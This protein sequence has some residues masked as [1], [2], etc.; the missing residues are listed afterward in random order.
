[1]TRTLLLFLLVIL[2]VSYA[3][4][5]PMARD[6]VWFLAGALSCHWLTKWWA[7]IQLPH[8]LRPR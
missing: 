8:E 1:M 5:E 3:H 7:S 2:G 4:P 6:L